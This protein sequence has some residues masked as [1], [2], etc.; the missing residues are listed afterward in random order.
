MCWIVCSFALFA[1]GVH[2]L[3]FTDG[4]EYGCFD[5]EQIE[6]VLGAEALLTPNGIATQVSSSSGNKDVDKRIRKILVKLFEAFEFKVSKRPAIRFYAD[7][8]SGAAWASAQRRQKFSP[9]IGLVMVGR[10]LIKNELKSELGG[11]AVVGI[12]AH[13]FAHIYQFEHGYYQRLLDA[14]IY[15]GKKTHRLNELH[16]DFLAGW[17]LGGMDFAVGLKQQRAFV[18]SFF[19]R[20]DFDQSN[21]QHHGSPAERLS[22]LFVGFMYGTLDRGRRISEI[23]QL[24]EQFLTECLPVRNCRPIISLEG[25]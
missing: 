15:S 4:C 23:A 21:V 20:G 10:T 13:E 7:P 16:A 25:E 11:T 3:E 14:S 8:G 2:S 22:A 12:L 24:G 18:N 5:L 9:S 17:F 6:K 19:A 1:R